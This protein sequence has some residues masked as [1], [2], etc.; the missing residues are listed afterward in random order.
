[1]LDSNNQ[2][3]IQTITEFLKILA[4]ENRLKIIQY[5]SSC[6]WCVSDIWQ[7]LDLPQNLISHHLKVLKEMGLVNIRKEGL[8]VYY[9][10][11]YE[12]FKKYKNLLINFI[13]DGHR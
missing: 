6:E 2:N 9:C 7:A 12:Q 10:L 1:M 4:E 5:L 8:R 11:N 3:E 13:P